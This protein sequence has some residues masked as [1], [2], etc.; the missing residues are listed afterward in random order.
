MGVHRV[1]VGGLVGVSGP[2]P[3]VLH[4]HGHAAR[5]R[6]VVFQHQGDLAATLSACSVVYGAGYER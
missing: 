3:A 1:D 6:P 2:G 4:V 5:E